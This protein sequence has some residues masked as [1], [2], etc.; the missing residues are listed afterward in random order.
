MFLLKREGCFLEEED[1]FIEIRECVL[2]KGWFFLSVFLK[3]FLFQKV[4][5][6]KLCFLLQVF[7]KV[8]F[9][10]AQSYSCFTCTVCVPS[11]LVLVV[12]QAAALQHM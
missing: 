6:T 5:S 10:S 4:V 7:Q 2:E 12:L 9:T 11:V 8:F 1:V 3:S